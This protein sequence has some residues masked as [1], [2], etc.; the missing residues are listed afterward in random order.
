MPVDNIEVDSMISKLSGNKACGP[1]SIPNK[2]LKTFKLYLVE[3]IKHL[4][5]LSFNEGIF[6]MLLKYANVCPI[7]KR[8]IRSFVRIT[9]LFLCSPT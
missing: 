4:I 7:Y 5:N 6:P 1:Y 2:I 9:G 3:P 8:K